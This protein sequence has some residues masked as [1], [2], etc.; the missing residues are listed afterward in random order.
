MKKKMHPSLIFL[1]KIQRVYPGPYGQT[2]KFESAGTSVTF[3]LP[4][5]KLNH[6][7]P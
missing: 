1:F 7:S 5:R 4:A 3:P 2:K 6:F